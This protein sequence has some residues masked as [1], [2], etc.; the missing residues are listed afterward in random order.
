[1]TGFVDEWVG[2]VVSEWVGRW[3]GGWF[4]SSNRN[5]IL[6]VHNLMGHKTQTLLNRDGAR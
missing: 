3:V 2:R 6:Y 1:M 4:H 5:F